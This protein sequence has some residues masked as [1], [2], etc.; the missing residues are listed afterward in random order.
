MWAWTPSLA[1]PLHWGG[2]CFQLCSYPGLSVS[3]RL[4]SPQCTEDDLRALFSAF[5]TVLEVNIPRKPGAGAGRGAGRG[6]GSL[7]VGAAVLAGFVLREPTSSPCR[8]ALD[9]RLCLGS[10]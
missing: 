6:L 10:S 2:G 7:G 8:G 9:C 4:A 3:P 1:V 5:G